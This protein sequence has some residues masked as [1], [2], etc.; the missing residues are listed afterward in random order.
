M[1]NTKLE[2]LSIL[3][4]QPSISGYYALKMLKNLDTR[5]QYPKV[6]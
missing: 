2:Y 6:E 3:W 4:K 5:V 1:N